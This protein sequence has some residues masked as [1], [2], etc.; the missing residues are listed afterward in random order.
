M[1]LVGVFGSPQDAY[2]YLREDYL[3]EEKAGQ[4]DWSVSPYNPE[5]W[6][7]YLPDRGGDEHYLLV[8][9]QVLEDHR[10]RSR[11]ARPAPRWRTS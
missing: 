3:G 2:H 6:T 1:S 7:G 9:E 5:C 8:R 11:F 10:S 4:I